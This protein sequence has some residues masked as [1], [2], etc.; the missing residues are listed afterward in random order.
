MKLKDVIKSLQWMSDT[1]PAGGETEVYLQTQEPGEPDQVA[2]E[3]FFIVPEQY[4][5]EVIDG[6][7]VE[8]YTAINVRTRPY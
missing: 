4:G 2:H 1:L 3:A 7:K 6:V 5:A 8:P